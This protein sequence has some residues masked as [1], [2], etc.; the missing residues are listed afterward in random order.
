MEEELIFEIRVKKWV[1]C[2]RED[3]R[4]LVIGSKWGVI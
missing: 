2:I 4:K 1:S 3:L